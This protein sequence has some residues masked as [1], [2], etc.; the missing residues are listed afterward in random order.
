MQRPT[1]PQIYI[2]DPNHHMKKVFLSAEVYAQA[3]QAMIIV[4]TDAVIINH[5]HQSIYL[6][7]RAIKP[8]QG[9]WWI[10]GRRLTGEDQLTSMK[11]CFKRETGL[12]LPS[13]RFTFVDTAEYIWKDR[14]QDPQDAGSHN[15]VHTFAIELNDAELAQARSG[16]EQGE[17]HRDFGLRE[18]RRPDL[19]KAKV[20]QV[21]LDVYDKIF[22]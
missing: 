6:A 16:L 21:I 11:R 19:V 20:H 2:E 22:S 5:A 7:E 13:E 17:Y 10:G 15:L 4:C 12:A 9:P 8:M 1:L 18:F 14:E 3:M